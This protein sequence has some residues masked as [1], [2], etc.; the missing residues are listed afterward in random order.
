VGRYDAL[1]DSARNGLAT[2]Q[3]AAARRLPRSGRHLS[4]SLGIRVMVA[5]AA[6]LTIEPQIS[7]AGY[8]ASEEPH[9]LSSNPLDAKPQ[10]WEAILDELEI[11]WTGEDRSDKV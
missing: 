4:S 8:L 6:W 5:K 3:K 11:S 10:N 2:H 7:L 9:F 1:V